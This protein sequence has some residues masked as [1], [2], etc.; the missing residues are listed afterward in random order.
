MAF[1]YDFDEYGVSLLPEPE[2]KE[3]LASF[4]KRL[5]RRTAL[6]EMESTHA[7]EFALADLRA[8]ADAEGETLTDL[9][10]GLRLSHRLCALL[11]AHTARLLGLPELVDRTLKTDVQGVVGADNF[12]LS[13]EWRNKG[14]R[15]VLRRIGSIL[16]TPE[17]EIKRIP[18]WMMEALDLADACQN[19]PNRFTDWEALARFR[20]ALSPAI[21]EGSIRHT[22]SN[23]IQISDFLKDLEVQIADRFS[24][25][26]NGAPEAADFE[27]LPFFGDDIEAKLQSSEDIKEDD[28]VLDQARLRTFWARTRDK[29][30]LPAYRVQNKSYLVI[31][32]AARPVLE[33]MTAKQRA[34]REERHAF[35]QNPKPEIAR[36]TEDYLR[37][38]GKLDGLDA[39]GEEE[40]IEQHAEP[41]FI[42]TREFSE[43][44]L[45]IAPYIQPDLDL[46]EA[47]GTT[48]LPEAFPKSVVESIA[49]Y[50]AQK[51]EELKTT[52]QQALDDNQQTVVIEGQTVPVENTLVADIDQRIAALNRDSNETTQ[53]KPDFTASEPRDRMVLKTADN[54]D[55][56]SWLPDRKPRIA[57]ITSEPPQLIKTKLRA[58]QIESLHHQIAAWKAGLPGVLNADEQGLGKTLQTI[59]FLRW[60]QD[61]MATEKAQPQGPLLIVAPTSLLQ[62]WEAEVERHVAK[63]GLGHL[64][65]LY[66]ASIAGR[67]FHGAQGRDIDSGKA[68]L[69][70]SH[71]TDALKE[72]RAHRFWLLTTY[73]TLTNYHH[74]LARI[75]FSCAVFDEIQA[76]KN[77]ISLRST[78]A[79]SVNANFRIGLT[80]TPIENSAVDLWAIMDQICPGAL[81]DLGKFR[82]RYGTANP[83]NMAELHQRVFKGQQG[84]PA[85][86][87]RRLKETV[88]GELPEKHRR[89]HPR[90]MSP[91][92]A[93]VYDE[94]REKLA[95][96]TK[97][98]ALKMLHHIRSVSVH[99]DVDSQA[100]A[101]NFIAASGR[102]Q[103]TFDILE[104]IKQRDERALVFIEHLKMQHRFIALA[105]ARFGMT[106]IDLINGSTPIQ[107]R[108]AI[109]DRFQR[110]QHH[111]S[112]FDILVLGPKAA[113]TG[114]TLTA[115]T[116]VIHLSRWWNPAVEEQCNDRVHRLGQNKPVTIHVPMSIHPTYRHQSFDCLLHNLMQ[117]KRQLSASALWPMGDQQEDA[118][119]LQELLS[120]EAKTVSGDALSSAIEE[121]F[122]TEGKQMPHWEADRSLRYA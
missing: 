79:R 23:H 27:I 106:N 21:P 3:I 55:E 48:W 19:E 108:Q 102:L 82:A 117:R 20:R 59:A 44:V 26:M 88:A 11:D 105:K 76:L 53:E 36:V 77:P 33:L 110:H 109:V 12:R 96:R 118:A 5:F 122:R 113:G 80:G 37:R 81:D 16:E 1:N 10:G 6:P 71:L 75:P 90:L 52:I 43:R 121:M 18:V 99:P 100:S 15:E 47:S 42:E 45:G 34:P 107:K 72:N 28:A 8:I 7:I 68:T 61:H 84:L 104:N 35:L 46:T 24:L 54:F 63:P 114:L 25:H 57:S 64:I 111:D 39:A 13:Y 95:A 115:A 69:D 73:Q 17:G 94:A 86:A 93:H 116:H 83:G 89:L 92:Q 87:F 49:S 66:G 103:A 58:Y 51:L 60:L 85:I 29:G 22:A 112:S 31:D 70:L 56:V 98:A 120:H 32:E 40:A 78:A 101:C 97:G 14:R 67:K 91:E 2:K 62:N 30:A 65:R 4:I 50:P 41:F 9:N 38:H 119:Q 74:S